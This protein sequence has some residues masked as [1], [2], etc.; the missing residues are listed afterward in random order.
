MRSVATV[1]GLLVALGGVY[2]V[3]QRSVTQGPLAQAPPQQQIAVVGVRSELLAIGQAERQYLVTH[4]T[5]GTLDE[6]LGERLMTGG[7][8]QRGY[9]FSVAVDGSR[10]FTATATPA[11]ASKAGWPTLT[12]NETML[13]TGQ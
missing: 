7:A 2:F 11:D 5:Y 8:D 9:V 6:L 3:Y 12:I 1:L 4:A 10:G 13:I